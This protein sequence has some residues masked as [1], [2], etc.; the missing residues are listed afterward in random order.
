MSSSGSIGLKPRGVHISRG[1]QDPHR[2]GHQG[3]DDRGRASFLEQI[4][5]RNGE[6]AANKWQVSSRDTPASSARLGL[7]QRD[8]CPMLAML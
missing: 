1:V 2:G 8:P 6:Q 3:I 5:V 4:S 7:L